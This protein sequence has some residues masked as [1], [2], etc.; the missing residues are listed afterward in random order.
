MGS[1]FCTKSI[2]KEMDNACVALEVFNGV[3]PEYMIEGNIK[4]GFKYVGTHMIF[5]IKIDGKFTR[6]SILVA[7]GH[8]TAPPSYITYSSV[9]ARKIVRLAFIISGINDLDLCV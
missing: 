9:V 4:P 7:S 5:D 8:K 2:E 6:K 1:T 3:T